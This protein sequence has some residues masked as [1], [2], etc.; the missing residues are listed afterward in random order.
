MQHHQTEEKT[1]VDVLIPKVNRSH[2][3]HRVRH[4]NQHTKLND[5]VKQQTSKQLGGSHQNLN[6]LGDEK[7]HPDN[8]HVRGRSKTQKRKSSSEEGG[9][10]EVG[11]LIGSFVKSVITPQQETNVIFNGMKWEHVSIDS[12]QN[13]VHNNNVDSDS[14]LLFWK[15]RRKKSKYHLDEPP[16]AIVDDRNLND[17]SGDDIQVGT[18][19]VSLPSFRGAYNIN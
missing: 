8:T 14:S 1:K 16:P 15:G 17:G 9:E 19:F 12:N 2:H 6:T 3:H 11:G 7:H 13:Y 5:I 10:N 18:I 4:H